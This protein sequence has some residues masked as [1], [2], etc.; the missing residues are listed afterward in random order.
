MSEVLLSELCSGATY[1]MKLVQAVRDIF[2]TFEK[3]IA[4]H[5][6]EIKKLREWK[7]NVEIRIENEKREDSGAMG[8]EVSE[9]HVSPRSSAPVLQDEVGGDKAHE[10]CTVHNV[11]GKHGTE[12]DSGRNV[13]TQTKE[14]DE[15]ARNENERTQNDGGDALSEIEAS[16]TN[17]SRPKIAQRN[18]KRPHEKALESCDDGEAVALPTWSEARDNVER[19][20]K[21]RRTLENLKPFPCAKCR[22]RKRAVMLRLHGRVDEEAFQKWASTR[23]NCL[24][25][26]HIYEDQER[27][28]QEEDS[29]DEMNRRDLR[30]N[31]KI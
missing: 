21:R 6:D 27:F 23:G 20:R 24:E 16:T 19:K 12:N 10:E 7:Q 28:S 4:N 1:N 8:K 18:A 29:N 14:A 17:G 15:N 25:Y 5:E 9:L 13:N 3:V 30:G 11:E 31:E 26:M 2:V 22:V